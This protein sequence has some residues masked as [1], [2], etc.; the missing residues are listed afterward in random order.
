M[1]KT[2]HYSL[3]ITE[4]QVVCIKGIGAEAND[5]PDSWVDKAVPAGHQKLSTFAQGMK[6]RRT[7]GS[8]LQSNL[9]E[10]SRTLKDASDAG[11]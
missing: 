4:Y 10:L 5:S 2:E 8:L 3:G 6:T 7:L 11:C 1:G 9:Q